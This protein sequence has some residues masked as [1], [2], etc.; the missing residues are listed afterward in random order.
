MG[1][2]LDCLTSTKANCSIWPSECQTPAPY[3]I[4]GGT[5]SRR[6]MFKKNGAV[7]QSGI[8]VCFR[9]VFCDLNGE[10]CLVSD[11][12]RLYT[13]PPAASAG[14]KG[15]IL[16]QRCSGFPP[17]VCALSCL[18]S[19]PVL[20]QTS[21]TGLTLLSLPPPHTH[22]LSTATVAKTLQLHFKLCWLSWNTLYLHF[23]LWSH[24]FF[25]SVPSVIPVARAPVQ[26][27]LPPFV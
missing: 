17:A 13:W 18:Y 3:W 8:S 27:R 26:T 2:R 5:G 21:H 14:R 15:L 7:L 12:S 4:S 10:S 20:S 19:A 9:V 25:P 11:G 1:V 16:P 6:H 22:T 23:Y 24:C